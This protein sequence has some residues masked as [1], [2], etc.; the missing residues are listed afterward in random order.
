MIQKKH[1]DF[2]YRMTFPN[3]YVSGAKIGACVTHKKRIISY[4][5]NQKKSHTIQARYG[6]Y[7]YLHAEIDAIRK[8]LFVL[9]PGIL[10]KCCVYV[11]R[12]KKNNK[13]GLSK[14]CIACQYVLD[15]FQVRQVWYSSDSGQ[16][17]EL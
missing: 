15:L 11:M 2:L 9:D 6:K 7:P 14:P 5:F 13:L 16:F 17:I 4:G 1:I 3:D 10:K 12:I 8:A